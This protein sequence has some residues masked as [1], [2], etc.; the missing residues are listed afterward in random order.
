M[1]THTHFTTHVPFTF[2]GLTLSNFRG[3][4]NADLLHLFTTINPDTK[5][6]NPHRTMETE[7]L[8]RFPA[9]VS[10]LSS[11][12]LFNSNINPYQDYASFDPFGVEGLLFF[13]SFPLFAF[14]FSSTLPPSAFS[15]FL[16]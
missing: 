3:E 6:M 2:F 1:H 8:G 16:F 15:F 10:S 9:R 12:L 11:V 13:T 4:T 14:V 5:A 7:G